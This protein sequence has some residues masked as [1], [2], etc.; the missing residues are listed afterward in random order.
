M[1]KVKFYFLILAVLMTAGFQTKAQVGTTVVDIIVNSPDHNTLE[2]AVTAAGLVPTLQGPGPF[3]VFAPTDEAFDALPPG[4]LAA[5]L[6]DIPAL[7]NILLYHVVGANALSSDLSSGLSIETLQGENVNVV[8]LNGTVYINNAKVTVADVV[9]DNGVVHVIDAVLL[10][11]ASLPSTVLDIISNSPV[12]Q[13]LDFALSAAGLDDDLQ[14]AGPFTVFAP[15]DAAFEALPEGLV[16]ELFSNPQELSKILLY[17]AVGA[18]AMSSSLSNGQKIKTLFGKNVTVTIN[19]D[20][21]FINNA[22]V[23]VADLEAENGVVHV[24]DAVLV[25]SADVKI[26]ETASKGKVITD[27][28]G[29]SLYFFTRDA[30]GTSMCTGG[31]LNNW[32]IFY[33]ENILAGAGLDPADFGTIDRG[34][35]VMQTT[36]KGWPLYYYVNDSQPGN[37]NGEG[38]AGRWFV[39]KPD[40]SI[41]IVDNQLTGLNGVNY[42][43]DYTPGDEVIQYFTDDKGLTLYTWKNDKFNTNKFTKPDFSNNGAW[44]IYEETEI[45]IPSVLNSADF[46]VINVH[47]RNQLTYKGWPLYYFGQDIYRKQP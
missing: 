15:T 17:H 11:P 27:S 2:A 13:D 47:G 43:G 26:V 30:K 33:A 39:A 38:L 1:R 7:T 35:G 3:T 25:P 45:T 29:R 32:P 21:I 37:M 44:P 46:G 34:S 6:A 5:L 40:Y 9:A 28:N 31:C 24:I 18:K 8:I 20:G 12:H 19:A 42:K 14:G 41:M 16:E 10:P 23:T 4:T 22:K 36:Y